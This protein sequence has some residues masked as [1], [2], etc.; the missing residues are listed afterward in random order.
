MKPRRSKS[1]LKPRQIVRDA[2]QAGKQ[3]TK[4]APESASGMQPPPKVVDKP[5][6]EPTQEPTPA[7]MPPPAKVEI[8]KPAQNTSWE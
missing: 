5:K 6:S 2:P 8:P 3:P 7:G 4:P 1:S